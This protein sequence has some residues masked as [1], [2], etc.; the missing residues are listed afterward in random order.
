MEDGAES[1]LFGLFDQLPLTGVTS[2]LAMV[3]IGIFFITSADSASVV[4]GTMT[5]RGRPEPSKWIVVFWG[6]CLSGIAIVMLLVGG[7]DALAGMQNLVIVS[8]LPFAVIMAFMM[9]ALYRDLR[10][11]PAT[12]RTRFALSAVEKAVSTGLAEHGD[13]FALQVEHAEGHRAAGDSFD[14]HDPAITEWYRQ[15]DENGD[16]TDFQ[17]KSRWVSSAV[18]DIVDQTP[19]GEAPWDQTTPH[20]ANQK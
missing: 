1:M 15:T 7:D 16:E 2:V 8:A 10:N 13:N 14:S 17:Y 6:A 12:L 11:D 9:V 18:D 5:Q 3:V 19:Q 4:M 20:N